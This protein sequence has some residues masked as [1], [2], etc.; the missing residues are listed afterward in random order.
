MGGTCS[1]YREVRNVNKILV[2]KPEGKR[3]FGRPRCKWEY[4]TRM[5]IRKQGGK[6]WTGCIWLRIETSG[7]LL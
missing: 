3:P 1:T 7:G 5:E 6:L 2:G 4:N